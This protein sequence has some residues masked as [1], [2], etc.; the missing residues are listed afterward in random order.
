MFHLKIKQIIPYK[1]LCTVYD[2][3]DAEWLLFGG[4]VVV[5]EIISIS[6][7]N[8]MMEVL[9]LEGFRGWIWVD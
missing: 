1:A 7:N 6:F 3:I 5:S 2:T 4:V 9:Y 8:S